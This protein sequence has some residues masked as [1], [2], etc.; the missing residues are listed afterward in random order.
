MA[1]SKL[2]SLDA[3]AAVASGDILYIVND[4]GGTPAGKKVTTD[5]LF[6]SPTITTPAITINE[7]IQAA[8]DTLTAAECS[9]TIINNYGQSADADLDLPAAAEGLGFTVILG[10]TTANF[11]R[12]TPAS[13]E[14]IA[15]DGAT[16]GANKYV[17]IASAAKYAAIE[18]RTIQTGAATWEWVAFTVSGLWV[19][20]A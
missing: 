10:T 5:V 3:L 12:F 20:E 18:F 7:I 1:D 19:Q 9:G 11:Y 17:Q 8:T 16:T 4:P 15:L 2:T 13:G 14:I 6:T